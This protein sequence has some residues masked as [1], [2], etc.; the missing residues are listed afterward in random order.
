MSFLSAD[1]IMY[2]PDAVSKTKS[3]PFDAYSI[4]PFNLLIEHAKAVSTNKNGIE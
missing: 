4:L 3:D 2:L 1:D